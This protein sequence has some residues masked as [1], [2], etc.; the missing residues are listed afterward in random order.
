MHDSRPEPSP[1]PPPCGRKKKNYHRGHRGHRGRRWKRRAALILKA[2]PLDGGG[3]GG[4]A[5]RRRTCLCTRALIQ[6][7]PRQR[8]TVRLHIGVRTFQRRPVVFPPFGGRRRLRWHAV[9]RIPGRRSGHG[10]LDLG[11]RHMRINSLPIILEKIGHVFNWEIG[12]S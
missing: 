8:Q 10:G 12:P 3:L 1:W 11:R 2:L 7:I 6:T 4:G 5:Q 9:W